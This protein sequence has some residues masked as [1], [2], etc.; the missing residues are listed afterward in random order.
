MQ[1]LIKYLTKLF[2]Q[3]ID[4]K[5]KIYNNKFQFLF[6]I[7][8]YIQKLLSLNIKV[9]IINYIYKTNKYKIS[10]LIIIEIIILNIIFYVVFYFIKEENYNNYI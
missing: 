4:L 2:N 8:K 10:F 6:F 5:K 1:A 7:F 3:Y 9:L